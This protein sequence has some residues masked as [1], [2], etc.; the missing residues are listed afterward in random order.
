MNIFISKPKCCI[1]CMYT[2]VGQNEL[3]SNRIKMFMHFKQ[4]QFVQTKY[5]KYVHVTHNRVTIV[6]LTHNCST[7]DYLT[8]K[9]ITIDEFV[10][11][12]NNR[13][14]IVEYFHKTA[15]VG[16]LLNLFIW[17]TIVRWLLSY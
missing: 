4:V 8:K 13:R 10:H 3:D 15:I 11:L 16:R 5:V 9:S 14:V 17:L 7:I 1:Q 12:I 6:L 2:S